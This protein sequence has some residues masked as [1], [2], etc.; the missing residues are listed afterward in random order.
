M[1]DVA[2]I[3]IYGHLLLQPMWLLS[4]YAPQKL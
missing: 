2:V 1:Q 4:V 3:I